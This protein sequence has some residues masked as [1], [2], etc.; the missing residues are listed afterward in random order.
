MN[1]LTWSSSSSVNGIII[2][3]IPPH[4]TGI[5]WKTTLFPQPVGAMRIRS[6]RRART[7]MAASCPGRGTNCRADRS[8]AISL[9]LFEESGIRLGLGRVS[10][11]KGMLGCCFNTSQPSTPQPRHME[12]YKLHSKVLLVE[13][14]LRANQEIQGLHVVG[15]R[16]G[17]SSTDFVS[18]SRSSKVHV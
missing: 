9:S 18:T 12:E 10:A 7:R 11:G 3:H 16:G 4:N 5:D 2:T 6:S 14:T 17:S 15:V 1:E 8:V 13:E